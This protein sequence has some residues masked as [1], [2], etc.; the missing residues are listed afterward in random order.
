MME[1]G[2]RGWEEVVFM[3]V[4]GWMPDHFRGFLWRGG[5]KIA[6]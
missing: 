2:E 4:E 1:Q 5:E 3:R 6:I